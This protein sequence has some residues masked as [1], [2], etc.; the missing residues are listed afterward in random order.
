MKSVCL[1]KI[2]T[3]KECVHTHEFTFTNPSSQTLKLRL[4]VVSYN[5][6]NHLRVQAHENL[7]ITKHLESTHGDESLQHRQLQ[8]VTQ[9]LLPSKPQILRQL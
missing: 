8:Q 5:T 9:Q 7:K 3:Q 2:F 1:Q 6:Q 4:Q